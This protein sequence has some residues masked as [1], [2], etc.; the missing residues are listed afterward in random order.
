M[1][2]AKPQAIEK[3]LY[4]MANVENLTRPHL[5]S[6]REFRPGRASEIYSGQQRLPLYNEK[7]MRDFDRI[8]GA[9]NEG[10]L[11]DIANNLVSSEEYRN[12][13]NENP[14]VRGMSFFAHPEPGFDSGIAF[15]ETNVLE[16]GPIAISHEGRH[17]EQ[18]TKKF[19]SESPVFSFNPEQSN[20]LWA[21]T[22]PLEFN[23][24]KNL[25]SI[26]S[27][28]GVHQDLTEL[29]LDAAMSEMGTMIKAG[30][31][32]R[33]SQYMYEKRNP[34]F[35]KRTKRDYKLLWD[36]LPPKAKKH[37]IETAALGGIATPSIGAFQPETRNK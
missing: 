26:D 27:F 10:K 14:E 11:S 35:A 36:V 22:D 7:F 19:G 8:T 23:R 13:I 5:K 16:A 3:I 33:T 1:P 20:A 18:A 6:I 32:N 28:S 24:S 2:I 4:H 29:E 34:E 30:D 15:P 25:G 17:F 37:F 21:K 9:M 31:T 12:I